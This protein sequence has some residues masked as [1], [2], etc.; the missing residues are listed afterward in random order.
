[1][2]R[3]GMGREGHF[4]ENCFVKNEWCDEYLYAI[5]SSEID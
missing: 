2:E 4:K 1:M 5:L 3:L